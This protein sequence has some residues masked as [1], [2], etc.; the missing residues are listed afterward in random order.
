MTATRQPVTTRR[1]IVLYSLVGVT[2]YLIA[3]LAGFPADRAYALTR[4]YLAPV[5]LYGLDGSL[6]RG[7]AEMLT[8]DKTAF[9][10][11]SWSISPWGLFLGRIST[12]WR[13]DQGDGRH[14]GHGRAGLSLIGAR[15]AVSEARLTLPAALV[16]SLFNSRPMSFQLG[17]TVHAELAEGRFDLPGGLPEVLR[18]RIQW[19]DASI[20]VR[21]TAALGDF[22][23]SLDTGEEGLSAALRDRGGPLEAQGLA[24]LD[25]QR[26]YVLK[27]HLAVRDSNR[28]DLINA[29]QFLRIFGKP[30]PGNSIAIERQGILPSPS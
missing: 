24:T 29:L 17:G 25:P 20:T 4:D 18:G 1:T 2:A 26:R 16:Q 8:I 10:S 28:R 7:R 9:R 13:F 30:G 14:R 11:V 6:W 5:S 21:E 3:L 12:D 27:V 15:A 23:I 22:D 19:L